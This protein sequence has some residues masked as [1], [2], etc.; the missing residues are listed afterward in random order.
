MDLNV[1]RHIKDLQEEDWDAAI[2]HYLGLDHVGHLGGPNSPL[3]L[4]KQKEMDL[5]I[6]SIYDIV[7]KQDEK[8]LQENKKG[9]LIVVCGDHGMNQVS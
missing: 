2:L 9:T 8:R 7:S 4:P 3:M 6:A 5:A 1:T